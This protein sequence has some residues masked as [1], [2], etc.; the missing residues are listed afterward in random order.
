MKRIRV[1]NVAHR[2]KVYFLVI[3]GCGV[4]KWFKIILGSCT[5][6]SYEL[7]GK[8]A[9]LNGLRGERMPNGFF[10]NCC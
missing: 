8:P 5:A 7:V 9:K 6:H 10:L 2:A 3:V 4:G 1:V